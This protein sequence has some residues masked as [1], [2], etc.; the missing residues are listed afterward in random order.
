MTDEKPAAVCRFYDAEDGLLYVG[1]SADPCGRDYVHQLYSP[2]YPSAVRR[3]DQW[4][5]NRA[6]AF[7]AEK[8]AIR[9]EHPAFNRQRYVRHVSSY[10]P[11]TIRVSVGERTEIDQMAED[12]ERDRSS[13]IR[14]LLKE[15]VEARKKRDARR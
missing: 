3:T 13:M 10:R 15:A 8:Q 6:E 1:S 5:A 12:E 4:Y 14:I 7:Q 9:V 11:V 2:W